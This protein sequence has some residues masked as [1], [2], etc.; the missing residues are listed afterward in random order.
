MKISSCGK[1]LVMRVLR[2]V[3]V[4]KL[5]QMKK[6]FS[7]HTFGQLGF[8]ILNILKSNFKMDQINFNFLA[9]DSQKI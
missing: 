3:G 4:K 7:L 5:I 1:L 9:K 8:V 6:D 2:K